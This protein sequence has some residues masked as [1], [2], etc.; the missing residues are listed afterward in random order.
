MQAEAQQQSG[1]YPVYCT[2]CSTYDYLP[3]GQVAYVCI[4]CKELLALR[5]RVWTLETT[6]TQLE[7][8]RETE[9][10]ID[11]TFRDTADWIPPCPDSIC[12]IEEDET[13]REGEP[14]LTPQPPP[15]C[16]LLHPNSL[17][18]REPECLTFRHPPLPQHS[19]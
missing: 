7:E 1:G 6:V 12:A 14:S 16:P 13:L 3:C 2:Q 18:L 9:K 5:D 17:P 19:R 11:E 8:L 4:Q 10:Y 15:L